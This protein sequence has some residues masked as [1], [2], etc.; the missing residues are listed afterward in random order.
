MDKKS[1]IFL[2]SGAII[3]LLIL[4]GINKCSSI[5]QEKSTSYNYLL[6]NQITKMNKMVVVEQDFSSIQKTKLSF[7]ILGKKIS[8]NE[9]VTLTN[10]NAQ[11]SYD[12]K[13]MKLEVDS[14]NKKLI[15]KELPNAEIKINPNVEIQSMDDSFINRIDE[16]QIKKV[17]KSAKDAA[18]KRV[19]QN[20]L[21]S[22]GRNQLKENLNQ[23]FILAKALKYEI[24]DE[25]GQIDTTKL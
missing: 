17:T 6:T 23:I 12:L 22:E 11:V 2:L 14:I 15:I 13:K 20:Q 19:D 18:V 24:V 4:F 8:D 1:I 5:S 9:I 7:E 21:R 3:V 10:T 25:T 16:N